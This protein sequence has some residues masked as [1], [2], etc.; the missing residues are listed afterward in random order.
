MRT[1]FDQLIEPGAHDTDVDFLRKVT[2]LMSILCEEAISSAARYS[3]C[4]GRCVITG[5]DILIAL[6][7]ESHKFWD[8]DIDARFL[9]RLQEERAHTYLTDDGSEE[10]DN[11][12]DVD[13]NQEAPSDGA[14]DRIANV[15]H[16]NEFYREILRIDHEWNDW[17]PVDPVKL[18][19]KK[20][21]ESTAA[22]YAL[23]GIDTG[24]TTLQSGI[25]DVAPD[26]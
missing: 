1:G 15:D 11:S 4:C 9:Q 14:Y 5:E 18:L 10:E 7:Y 16:E 26:E 20:A 23:G 12:D 17:N 19:L 2:A 6:K 8:K 13:E 3:A 25:G 22:K 21:I 24:P